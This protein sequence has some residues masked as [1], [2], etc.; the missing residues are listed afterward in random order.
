MKVCSPVILLT[1]RELEVVER[2]PAVRHLVQ[3]LRLVVPGEHLLEGEIRHLVDLH[4]L[5]LAL[6]ALPALA[7]LLLGVDNGD[8]GEKAQ[9]DRNQWADPS[10]HRFRLL[11]RLSRAAV[12]ARCAGHRGGA[13]ARTASLSQ[14]TR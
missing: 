2:G 1:A 9:P 7:R 10:L 4:P 8:D 11:S 6:Q 5:R 12:G 3:P 14:V 13:P